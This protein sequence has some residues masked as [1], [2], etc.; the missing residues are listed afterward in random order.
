MIF[1]ILCSGTQ[2]HTSL[3]YIET[4]HEIGYYVR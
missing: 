3:Y 1:P 4:A 2:N